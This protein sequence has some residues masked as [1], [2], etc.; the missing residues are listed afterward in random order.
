M[1]NSPAPRSGDTPG[2]NY[3]IDTTTTAAIKAAEPGAPTKTTTLSRRSNQATAGNPSSI[4]RRGSSSKD[5]KHGERVYHRDRLREARYAA[6][7]DAEGFGIIWFALEALG[8]RLHGT[9]AAL[10]TDRPKLAICAANS[11]ALTD[12]PER[13]PSAFNA[14][15]ALFKTLQTA[16]ND[17]IHIG[18]WSSRTCAPAPTRDSVTPEG[19]RVSTGT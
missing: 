1:R 5:L 12:L 16:R 13:F 2:R 6:Q 11:P 14:F 4:P 7:E 19:S 10:D 15:E 3:P 18:A 8:L 9:Q 17:A